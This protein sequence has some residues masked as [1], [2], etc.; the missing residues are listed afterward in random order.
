MSIS[1]LDTKDLETERASLADELESLIDALPDD[2]GAEDGD[3]DETRREEYVEAAE[4]L[5]SFLGVYEQDHLEF[6][7]SRAWTQ[8]YDYLLDRWSREGSE[9]YELKELEDLCAEISG[10]RDGVTLIDA[11]DFQ[12]YAMEL[13]S[14][15]A[16]EDL[17]AWPFDCIDWSQAAEALARDY[18]DVSFRGTDYHYASRW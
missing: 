6:I 18:Q 8:G 3:D 15:T 12:D 1:T 5:A 4:L 9:G 16:S 14:D 11:D 7:G 2:T 17:S 10:W 13:A